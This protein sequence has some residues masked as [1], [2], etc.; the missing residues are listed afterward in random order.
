MTAV[1]VLVA[2]ALLVSACATGGTG[3]RDEGPARAET[4]ASSGAEKA[5]GAS[6]PSPDASV[7]LSDAARLVKDDPSVSAEVKSDLRPCSGDDYPVDVTSGELTGGSARDVVVN[8]VTCGDLIGIGSYVYRLVD[9]SYENVFKAEESPV[10]AQIDRGDLVVTRQVYK[11]GDAVAKPSGE[12]V[13]TYRW[14]SDRFV[15]R[16]DQYNEYTTGLSAEAPSPAP[17]A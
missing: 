9:G 2:V 16:W 10:Y 12:Y 3:A 15:K 11:R 5:A 8:V 17:S 6:V 7:S 13:I 4:A 14:T 1:A